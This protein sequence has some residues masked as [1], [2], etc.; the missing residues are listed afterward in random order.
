MKKE[1][2]RED[3]AVLRHPYVTAALAC[4]VSVF[5]F[6]YTADKLTP[7][8]IVLL[9]A[10]ALTLIAL[11]A[12]WYA[13]G[14]LTPRRVTFLILAFS[15]LVKLAY[16]LCTGL[17]ERQHDV[18]TFRE[19]S[20]GHAGRIFR[21]YGG[22]IFPEKIASM[23]Y[24]PPL[25]YGLE[26]LWM[27]FLTWT[28]V[29]ESVAT[30]YVTALTLFYSCAASSV[31]AAIFK[32]TGL[33]D[34]SRNIALSLVA[35]HPTFIILAAS[36][37]NDMLSVLFMLAA[38]LFAIRWYRSPGYGNIVCLALAIGL[39][40]MSKLSAGYVAP[41][42][43]M[44]FLIKFIEAKGE[45]LRL[46]LQYCVFGAVCVPL[47]TWWSF[48]MLWEHGKPLGYVMKLSDKL[49][50]YIGFRSV[51]ERLLGIP[52]SFSEGI[53]F[54]R[55]D[56]GYTNSF[57]EYNIPSAVVKTSVFGEWDIGKGGAF[58]EIL[59]YALII[60]N[61]ILIVFSIWCMGRAVRK[62]FERFEKPVKAFFY[63][64]WITVVLMYVK[65]CF[66]FPHNCTMDFRYI[67]PAAVVG[68]MFIGLYSD[69]LQNKHAK[70]AVAAVCI[71]FCAVSA[72]LYVITA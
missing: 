3:G 19:V 44:L 2:L 71:A 48:Y 50:Q 47:G 39:G 60:L 49:D 52:H 16:V 32:E 37:N 7:F 62:K 63:A 14:M 72:L 13:N 17:G 54:A 40:M 36:Y 55:A 26:A 30:H 22:E 28:G 5:L 6:D 70:R 68:A 25:H 1:F 53:W 35:F 66:D 57:F 42:V 33:G 4:L 15:F 38:L 67:V 27:K 45:R 9:A 20:N 23:W 34:R 21:M 41:A 10:A 18:G 12:Y 58:T 59:A 24:H 56:Q 51:T 29:A 69:T 61:V 43:A 31:C 46:F 11:A 8:S 64:F 65:F